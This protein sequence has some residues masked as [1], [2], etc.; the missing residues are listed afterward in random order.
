[1]LNLYDDK[2]TEKLLITEQ[3]I[4]SI[5]NEYSIYKLCVGDFEIN[6]TFVS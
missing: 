2:Y 3:N 5:I 6:K 1:M 4:L